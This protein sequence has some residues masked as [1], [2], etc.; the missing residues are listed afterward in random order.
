MCGVRTF[1]LLALAVACS[2]SPVDALRVAVRAA[3]PPPNGRTG[4]VEVDGC[5]MEVELPNSPEAGS[6]VRVRVK[7]TNTG[8]VPVAVMRESREPL[9]FDLELETGG[10]PVPLTRYGVKRIAPT[11][12]LDQIRKAIGSGRLGK[13][14]PGKTTELD[15]PNLA[16]FYDLTVQGDYDLTISRYVTVGEGPSAKGV[17]L[18]VKGLRLTISNP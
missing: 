10:K 15:L 12:L 9:P 2:S 3:A 14:E 17:N 13:L 18:Q 6:P 8:K 5:T 1:L 7:I 4:S 11:E 16:L